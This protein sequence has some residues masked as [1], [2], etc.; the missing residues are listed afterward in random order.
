MIDVEAVI[1]NTIATAFD[2][3]YPAGSRYSEENVSPAKFP[4]LTLIE[5]DNYTYE[6]S[7]DTAMTE[8]DAWLT[9]EVNVYSNKSF[10]AKQECK[11]IVSLV[12]E[13]MQHLGFTRTFCSQTKN[14]DQK[15]YRM[16]ARYRAVISEK[17]RIYR[18]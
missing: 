17:Y 5:T 10:G 1:F 12:D 6:R 14:A 3:A 18:S 2:N 13:Q 16:T 11:A 15:I 7:L 4:C 8:H 9:Y